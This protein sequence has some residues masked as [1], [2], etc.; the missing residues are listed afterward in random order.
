M[1]HLVLIAVAAVVV[2]FLVAGCVPPKPP[3]D[4]WTYVGTWV[5]P[6]NNGHGISGPPGKIVITADSMA[7]YD[8]DTDTTPNVTTSLTVVDDWTSGGDHYFKG[9]GVATS[10]TATGT[11]F[12]FLFCVSNN[13]NTLEGYLSTTDYPTS[14]LGRPDSTF[15]RG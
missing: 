13:N 12:Y 3:E 5:N 14:L 15:T 9:Y 10:G 4:S 7:N 1:K 11:H 2:A 6:A 8:N